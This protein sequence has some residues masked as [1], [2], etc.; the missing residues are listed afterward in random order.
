ML[1]GCCAAGRT[2]ALY[3]IDD[4]MGK[5]YYVEMEIQNIKTSARCFPAES[6]LK[7]HRHIGC[8]VKWKPQSQSFEVT[9]KISVL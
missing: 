6:W 8:K 5:E 2:G 3:K 1:C 4:N 7:A 9:I